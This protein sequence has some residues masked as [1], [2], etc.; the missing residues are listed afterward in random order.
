LLAGTRAL[1][2]GCPNE[3]NT[4]VHFVRRPTAVNKLSGRHPDRL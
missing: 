4:P 3:A 2:F 1:D